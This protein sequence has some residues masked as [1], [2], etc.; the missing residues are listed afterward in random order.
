MC[1]EIQ[2]LDVGILEEIWRRFFISIIINNKLLNN[3]GFQPSVAQYC[4]F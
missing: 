3:K 1:V 4:K 2:A